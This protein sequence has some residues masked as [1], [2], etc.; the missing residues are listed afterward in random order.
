M[1]SVDFRWAVMAIRIQREVGGNLAEL[2]TK[3]ADTLREREYLDG[4]SSRSR[5]KAA[6]RP[7]S[8]A[9]CP[10]L[11]GLLVRHEPDYLPALHEPVGYVMLGVMCVL[12][13]ARQLHDEPLVKLEI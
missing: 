8:S 2:L 13:S 7:T 6:S 11:H 10:R 3:V 9:G 4:R 1:Q 5:R 12:M